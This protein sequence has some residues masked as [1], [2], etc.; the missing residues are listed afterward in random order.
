MMIAGVMFFMYTV[1]H[2]IEPK[3]NCKSKNNSKSKNSI[4]L[5]NMKL[6]LKNGISFSPIE[7]NLTSSKI[8]PIFASDTVNI[9]TDCQ[10]LILPVD[11]EIL[12]YNSKPRCQKRIRILQELHVIMPNGSIMYDYFNP[13][14][15][16]KIGHS[17]S[18]NII[19][20]ILPQGIKIQMDSI[21]TITTMEQCV[22]FVK[23]TRFIQ[24]K[25]SEISIG[26]LKVIM[27]DT[28]HHVRLDDIPKCY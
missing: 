4:K 14:I 25:D 13:E 2:D 22:S 15:K 9:I 21:K 26:E 7:C 6:Y 5:K 1:N 18:S 23:G 8:E 16:Y 3:N 19:F 20:F 11:T 28:C 12:L 24:P 17:D 10:E 27:K